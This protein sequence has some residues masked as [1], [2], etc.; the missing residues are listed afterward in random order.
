MNPVPQPAASLPDDATSGDSAPRVL[1]VEDDSDSQYI[2]RIFLD[3]HGFQ[4]LSAGTSQ[5]G[6]RLARE[7]KPDVILM[8]VSIPGMDGWTTTRLLKREPDTSSIPV[9]VITAHAF[10]E[11]RERAREAGC[12]GFLSKPCELARIKEEILRVLNDGGTGAADV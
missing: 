8:D 12:D 3:H 7:S 1:I 5:E 11:D 4:V 9:I 6:V 2:Y 10:P